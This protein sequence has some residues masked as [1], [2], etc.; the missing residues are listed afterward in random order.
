MKKFMSLVTATLLCCLLSACTP[1]PYREDYSP[2]NIPG[3]GNV[4]VDR[5]GRIRSEMF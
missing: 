4:L 1:A 5:R 2:G 3:E